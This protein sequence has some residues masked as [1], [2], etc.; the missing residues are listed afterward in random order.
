M[1]RWFC[2]LKRSSYN[3]SLAFGLK[4]ANQ[5]T[6]RTESTCVFDEICHGLNVE[7][8]ITSLANIVVYIP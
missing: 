1:L 2:I 7:L 6:L 8:P 4:R 5:Y 3:R